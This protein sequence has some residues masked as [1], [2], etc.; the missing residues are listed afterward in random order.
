MVFAVLFL[1]PLIISF[2][3][4]MIFEKE[5][6]LKEFIIQMCIQ[7]VV[8][9]ASAGILYYQNVDDHEVWNGTVLKKAREKVSCEHSYSCNC[10]SVSC[11]K[12]CSTTV[13]STCYEHSYDVDWA[14]YTSNGERMTID[15]VD[16]Q[17]VDEP[18][19]YDKVS[20]G[21][22]TSVVHQ[23]VN[24]IKA[25]PNTLFR[26]QG[27]LEKFQNA[28]PG[29]P[30]NIYDY[31]RLDRLV[32]VNGA[33]L[34]NTAAWNTQLAALNGKIGRQKQCNIITVFT[35]GLPEDY[36]YALEQSWIGGKQNDITVV[37]N[38]TADGKIEWVGIMAWTKN[39]LFRVK[40]RDDIKDLGTVDKDKFFQVLEK[41]VTTYFVRKHMSDFEYLKAS[42]TPTKNEWIISMIISLLV[43][44]GLSIFFYKVDINDINGNY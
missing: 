42:I 30:Q 8:A 4:F 5:I 9:G 26:H 37:T 21:E 32:L 27:L 41:D 29:Y 17:G 24:Y 1:V 15:R 36:Y 19:R 39:E 25:A 22:P 6:T 44:I 43:A 31:Y 23:F 40:L 14:V 35:K 34:E 28:L 2:F 18:P 13:C 33:A 16:R 3:A 38:L 12:N 7:A 20:V 10:H 11:G